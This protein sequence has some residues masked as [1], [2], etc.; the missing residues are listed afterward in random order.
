MK[1]A[2]LLKAVSSTIALALVATSALAAT[3]AQELPVQENNARPAVVEEAKGNTVLEIL[4]EKAKE[5]NIAE[6]KEVKTSFVTSEK[7]APAEKLVRVEETA[8]PEAAP[9]KAAEDN[10][11]AETPEK[12]EPVM[13]WDISA[14]GS[15]HV[16]MSFYAEKTAGQVDVDTQTGVVY[17][18][19]TGAMEDAVYSHFVSVEKYLAAVKA[20]F[21]EHYGVEVDLVYDEAITDV[22]ELDCNIR[23]FAHETGEELFVTDEIHQN[24]NP[25]AFLAYSPKTII[26]EEGV[27]NVSDFAFILCADIE[28]VVLPSTVETIGQAAFEFCDSLTDILMPEDVVIGTYAFIFCDNLVNVRFANDDYYN[29]NGGMTVQADEENPNVRTLTAEEVSALI[30]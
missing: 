29:S 19:G 5:E 18:R 17:I 1:K 13:V 3:P 14:S 24:V 20:L 27:T 22:I 26:I 9:V 16:A 28:T 15:D 2:L 6:V 4:E 10:Q 25:A 21:E 8:V 30:H 11:I 7:A 23:F 12:A